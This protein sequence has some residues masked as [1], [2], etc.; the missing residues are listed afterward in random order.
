VQFTNKE[1][2]SEPT[3]L[4]IA[5]QAADNPGSFKTTANNISSRP[6][7]AAQ[8]VW[9]PAPWTVVNE[10]GPNQRTPDLSSVLQEIVNRPGW[11]SGNAMVFVVTGTGCRTA[12]AY[13]Q[14]PTVAARLVVTYQ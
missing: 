14:S 4:T 2:K 6:R 9:N 5:A 3:Q 11:T 10:A 13:D 1:A 8:V 12:F 7:T